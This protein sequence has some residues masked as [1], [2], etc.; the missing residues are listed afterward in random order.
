M[1]QPN[2][3]GAHQ[4]LVAFAQQLFVLL[5]PDFVHRFAHQFTDVEAVKHDLGFREHRLRG[6]LVGRAE[7]H[8]HCLDPVRGLVREL[9]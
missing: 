4:T 5:T 9:F 3:P 7:V 8:C 1:V 6:A 2:V